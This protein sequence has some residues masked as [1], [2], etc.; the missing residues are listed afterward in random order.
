MP[1]RIQREFVAISPS[2]GSRAQVN[3]VYHKKIKLLLKSFLMLSS[4]C[5][6]LSMNPKDVKILTTTASISLNTLT[7]APP[8]RSNPNP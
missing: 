3:F 6:S 1:S 2:T 7:A 4:I 8:Q 5:K